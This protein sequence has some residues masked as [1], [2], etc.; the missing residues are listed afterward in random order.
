MHTLTPPSVGVAGASDSTGTGPG[1]G[2]YAE[3]N[4]T[5]NGTAAPL[6]FSTTSS[7]SSLE[8]QQP[9]NLSERLEQALPTAAAMLATFNSEHTEELRRKYPK[10]SELR[11]DRD[12]RDYN[13]KV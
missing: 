6:D 10:S 13:N 12:I 3:V 2:S 7:S 8:D 4:G 5:A 9:V 1:S 11:L